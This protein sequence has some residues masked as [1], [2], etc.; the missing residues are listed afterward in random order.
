MIFVI[1][2][3]KFSLDNLKL[4]FF[5]CQIAKAFAKVNRK[6]TF[7]SEQLYFGNQVTETS[8]V[9]ARESLRIYFHPINGTQITLI[10]AI[11]FG[12]HEAC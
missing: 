2:N 12:R 9:G 10:G 1:K 11:Y 4:R 8:K 3:G 7:F 5:W 6:K